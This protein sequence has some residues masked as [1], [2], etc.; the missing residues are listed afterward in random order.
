MNS[1]ILYSRQDPDNI[2]SEHLLSRA[3]EL[4]R[5]LAE[6]VNDIQMAFGEVLASNIEGPSPPAVSIMQELD[7]ASQTLSALSRLFDWQSHSVFSETFPAS[8][9]ERVVAL[10]SVSDFLLDRIVECSTDQDE[11]WE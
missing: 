5:K 6:V 4:N 11:L 9:I 7:R 8:E 3:S 2:S 1:K 10:R